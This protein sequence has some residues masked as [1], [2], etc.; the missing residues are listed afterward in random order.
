MSLVQFQNLPSTTTPL[1][2]SN[3]NNNFNEL[4]QN[5]NTL[6]TNTNTSLDNGHVDGNNGY[7]GLVKKSVR[8][9]QTVYTF[10]VPNNQTGGF[11]RSAIAVCGDKGLMLIQWSGNNSMT[12]RIRWSSFTATDV[13][14]SHSS[15][16]LTI[17]FPSTVYG[18]V[19]LI[20]TN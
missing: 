4:S 15:G 11:I 20:F 10:N 9:S 19:D 6:N 1:N 16:V 7:G 8:A 14:I 13:T 18:S 12:P 17:T 5:I 3:L 2:A